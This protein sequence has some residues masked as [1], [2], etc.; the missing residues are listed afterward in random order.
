MHEEPVYF[1]HESWGNG[2]F[3]IDSHGATVLW[4]ILK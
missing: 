3:H 1:S 2:H 4:I